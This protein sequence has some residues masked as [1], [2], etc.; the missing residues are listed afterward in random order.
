MLPKRAN[1]ILLPEQVRIA[2]LGRFRSASTENTDIRRQRATKVAS[3][4]LQK[5]T[6]C[7]AYNSDNIMAMDYGFTAGVT[8]LFIWVSRGPGLGRSKRPR[9]RS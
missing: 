9:I 7:P 2:R 1:G 6:A 5:I 8:H 3:I 4:F